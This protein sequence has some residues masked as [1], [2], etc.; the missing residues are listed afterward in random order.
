M[1][2]QDECRAPAGWTQG[3]GS[4]EAPTL[5]VEVALVPRISNSSGLAEDPA[6]A[7]PDPCP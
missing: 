1:I 3:H 4:H 2:A 7:E 5:V 6:R